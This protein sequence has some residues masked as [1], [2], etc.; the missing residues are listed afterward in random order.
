M[1]PVALVTGAA[2]GIGKAIAEGLEVK[3]FTVA[4]MDRSWPDGQGGYVA[5]LADIAGHERLVASIVRDH[6]AIDCL[7]NNAGIG[8]VARGDFLDMTP[9]NFDRVMAVNLRGTVF[10][11][12]AVVKAM[13]APSPYPRSIVTISSVSAELASIERLDYCMSKAA[14][15]MFI[16]GLALRLAPQGIGVFDIRPGIIRSEMTAP[17]TAK[18]DARIAEGL[19]PAMRWGEPQD[20]AAVVAALAT[21]AMNFATGSVIH[22]DGGLAIARL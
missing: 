21:G 13:Q 15:A 14:L 16:K 19:V 3:G 8:A 9:E 6:G 11:T 7:V 2:R 10:L 4:G 18:Y 12:Q 5:D 22:A 20:V 17:V 1:K